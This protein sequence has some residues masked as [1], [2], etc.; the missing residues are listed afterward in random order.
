MS[1]IKNF[2]L[3]F[4]DNCD[5]IKGGNLYHF[6]NINKTDGLEW[7]KKRTNPNT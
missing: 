3:D 4:V 2:P 7:K 1:N 5:I 6:D